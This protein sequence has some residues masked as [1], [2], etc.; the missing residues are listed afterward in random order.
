MHSLAER[1]V[2]M[3]CKPKFREHRG[4]QDVVSTFLGLI[5]TTLIAHIDILLKKNN[6]SITTDNMKVAQIEK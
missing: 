5:F 6:K 4:I 3:A 2:A 1:P